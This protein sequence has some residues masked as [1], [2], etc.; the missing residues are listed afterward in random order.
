MPCYSQRPTARIVR[1]IGIALFIL[2][3]SILALLA[4]PFI[5]LYELLTGASEGPGD[6]LQDRLDEQDVDAKFTVPN[7][8]SRR[9][10][11]WSRVK[12]KLRPGDELWSYSSPPE[13]WQ[14]LCGREGVCVMR[15]EKVV[16]NIITLMN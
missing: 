5:L 7:T 8:T 1:G 16:A 12:G 13:T 9:A 4:L 6:W 15:G 3:F 11:E 10:K 14:K 2:V